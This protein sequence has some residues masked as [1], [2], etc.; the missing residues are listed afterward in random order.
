MKNKNQKF[1]VVWDSFYSHIK[2]EKPNWDE[3][4]D[5]FKSF[6]VAKKALLDYMTQIRN[7]WN[8]EIYRVRKIN[9]KD[10]NKKVEE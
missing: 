1:Y 9:K 8:D 5:E 10:F 4:F 3:N 7:E 2:D 6:Q